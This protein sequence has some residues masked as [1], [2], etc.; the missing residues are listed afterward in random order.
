MITLPW[1]VLN[2]VWQ[3]AQETLYHFSDSDFA[4]CRRTAK[5]MNG[6][7]IMIGKHNIKRRSSTGKTVALISAEAE[8]TAVVKCSCETIGVLQL[9]EDWR[10]KLECEAL[11]D[12]L[13]ALEVVGI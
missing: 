10:I 3:T 12:S 5:S 4:G 1:T 9:A 2:C 8:L 11:K 7:V 6:G 13:A